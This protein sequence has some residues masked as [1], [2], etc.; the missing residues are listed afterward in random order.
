MLHLAATATHT[1]T[2]HSHHLPGVGV[3][4]LIG[5]AWAAG[6]LFLCWVWPFVNCRRCSG[7]GKRR[8]LVGQG[9]RHCPRCDGTGHQLRPGRHV[10]NHLRTIHDRASK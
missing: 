2:T 10:L 5:L 1:A 8:A 3:L 9:F 4:F 7:S 6:Y